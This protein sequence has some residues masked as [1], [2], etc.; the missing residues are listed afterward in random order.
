L[1]RNVFPFID[2]LDYYGTDV[3]YFKVGQSV[4]NG[5][6]L[7]SKENLSGIPFKETENTRTEHIHSIKSCYPDAKIILFVRNNGWLDSLYS[8]YVKGG[9]V[10]DRVQWEQQI[11]NSSYLDFE[12]YIKQLRDN[13]DEVY[14]ESFEYFKHNTF[15]SILHLCEFMN[16]KVP[17]YKTDKLGV[18]LSPKKLELLRLLNLL[19]VKFKYMFDKWDKY[20]LR[21]CK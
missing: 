20:K 12:G 11:F 4:G 9:G 5:K 2:G 17:Q 1:Q 3:R 19:P 10:L 16:V 13:F 18:K 7:V 8:Q 15:L 21:F 14:V 6:T